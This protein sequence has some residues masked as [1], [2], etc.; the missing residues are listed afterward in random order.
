M[1][2]PKFYVQQFA[3]L[4]QIPRSTVE[5]FRHQEF[6]DFTSISY[7]ETIPPNL[8]QENRP[9]GELRDVSMLVNSLNSPNPK[10]ILYTFSNPV[11]VGGSNRLYA[12]LKK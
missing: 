1:D 3:Q 8:L 7:C 6:T 11:T 5:C 2:Y 12:N 4:F 9:L 10:V